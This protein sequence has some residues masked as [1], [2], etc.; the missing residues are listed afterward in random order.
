M[1]P[2][3]WNTFT[4]KISALGQPPAPMFVTSSKSLQK[5]FYLRLGISGKSRKSKIQNFQKTTTFNDLF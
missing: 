3:M 1:Y 5:R 2:Y 4:A